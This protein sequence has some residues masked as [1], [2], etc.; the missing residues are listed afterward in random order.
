M[1]AALRAIL[2]RHNALEEGPEGLY[3]TCERLAGAEAEALL[4]KM[5]AASEVPAAA[6]VDGPRILEA[7][8][9]ALARAGY[10]L[11]DYESDDR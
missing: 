4:A 5:R 1:V 8:R 3:A 11:R 10:D 9:R 7:T 2:A 6:H